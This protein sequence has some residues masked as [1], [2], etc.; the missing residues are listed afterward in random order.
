MM[1]INRAAT[2]L[3]KKFA[4]DVDIFRVLDKKVVISW[5]EQIAGQGEKYLL[6]RNQ[7]AFLIGEIQDFA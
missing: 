5:A 4:V 6:T 2:V 1:N 3:A 7:H